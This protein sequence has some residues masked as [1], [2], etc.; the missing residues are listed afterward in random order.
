MLLLLASCSQAQQDEW[1]RG[2]MPEAAS[3]RSNVMIEFWQWT[4]VAA[5]VVGVLVWGLI[6]Y[7]VIK[8]RRRSDD[9]VPLQT[10][11]NLPMEILYTVAP[12]IVVLVLFDYVVKVQ[13][14]VKAA[15]EPDHIIKVVGQKWSWSFNYYKDDAIGGQTVNVVGT[16]ADPPTLVLPVDEVVRF[17]LDS[18]DV[19]HSFWVAGFHYKED[20]IPGKTN[21]F[22][23]TPTRKG[24]YRGKCAE[25]CG[26]YHSRMLFNVKIVSADEYDAYLKTL[27]QNPDHVGLFE[28]A[29]YAR[30]QAGL[31][32][33]GGAE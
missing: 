14:E 33:Q 27:S 11:Y 9:E 26:V 7:S 1:K 24:D 25:L 31:E 18:P 6:F 22:T 8:F 10:R 17:D 15:P 12:V 16:P 30:T 32:T 21:T 28:G 5:L 29:D 2:A 3:D 20:V 13:D 23:L 19:I 4:W